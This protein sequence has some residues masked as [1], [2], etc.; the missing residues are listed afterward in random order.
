M[1]ALD[2][3]VPRLV[4]RTRL[5]DPYVVGGARAYF[6]GTQ[7]GRCPPLGDHIPGAMGGLWIHP[8]RLL[9]GLV[10]GWAR[11]SEPPSWLA[12][13]E[14]RQGPWFAE[15]CYAPADTLT[16]VCRQ[17]VPDRRPGLVVTWSLTNADRVPHALDLWVA[18]Q[19]DLR[20]GWLDEGPRG[21]DLLEETPGG[22]DLRSSERGWTARVIGDGNPEWVRTPTGIPFADNP[23]R[24][25]WAARWRLLVA[26]SDTVV[27]SLWV[28]ADDDAPDSGG[29]DVVVWWE[30]KRRRYQRIRDTAR[31]DVPDAAVQ[32]ALEWSK[33]QIDWLVREVPE[34][35]TGLGAGLPEYPWWFACDNY[36]ALQAAVMVGRHRLAQETLTLLADVSRRHN[37]N[38]RI[39]HE[40]STTGRVYN[41][42]N[43]QESPQ[44]VTAVWN[45][46]AWTGDREWLRTLYPMVRDSIGWILG[47]DETG[48]DLAPGY[49]IIE[50]DGLN[51]RLLD[52]AVYTWT[53]LRAAAQIA[54]TLGQYD[55]ARRWRERARRLGSR[56]LTLYWIPEE[57]L[58][59]D[60]LAGRAWMRERRERWASW[61]ER[62]G[63]PDVADRYRTLSAYPRSDDEAVLLMKNWIISVPMEVGLAPRSYAVK[64]LRRMRGPEFRGPWGLYLSG[65]EHSDMMTISTGVQAVAETRYGQSDA[66]LEWMRAMALT[67]DQRM[68]GSMSEMSPDAGC[69]VQAWSAYGLW[70]P[71]VTGFFGIRPRAADR[72]LWVAPRMPRSWT[73]AHLEN[74]PVGSNQ[75]SCSYRTGAVGELHLHTAESWTVTYARGWEVSTIRRGAQ[76][77][78]RTVELQSDGTLI[79]KRVAHR[80]T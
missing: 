19:S 33:Y 64:A 36:Y 75:F 58:F 55:Q 76:T 24:A 57:Q 46:Y 7:D 14:Y 45:T 56:I 21:R 80:T 17:W 60:V 16:L 74:L 40:V 5:T 3:S 18:F 26:P 54:E 12:A 67:M 63:K 13:E 25:T 27:R 6:I 77:G 20:P 34:M 61:A 35:G 48:R 79:L 70:V 50:I 39:I 29:G 31:V 4:K 78:P 69:F 23:E 10:T 62:R 71:V 42:G 9:H 32:H 1:R 44:F 2:V 72:R 41:S 49:G 28:G 68:P 65:T 53:G 51:A 11:P 8:Y 52:T 38:G 66:A 59:G 37:G 30:S 73:E 22:V 43:H 15:L 47:Q